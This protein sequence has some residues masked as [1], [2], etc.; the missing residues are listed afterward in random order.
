M[1]L[2][3]ESQWTVIACGV[4]AHADGVLDGEECDL[5]LAMIEGEADG[6]EYSAWLSTISD[7]ERLE[8][9]LSQLAPP[10]QSA[11]RDILETAWT[12]AVADGVRTSSER[13]ALGRIATQL[14]VEEVQLEFWREAWTE[15]QS[16]LAELVTDA[17]CIVLAGEAPLNSEARTT[18]R[19][20]SR[21][22]PTTDAHREELVGATA[23]PKNAEDIGRR[24][25]GIPKRR[26]QWVIKALAG[27]PG[28]ASRREDAQRR[29]AAIGA[30]AGLSAQ[31]LA[32]LLGSES[33]LRELLAET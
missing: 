8:E 19:A 6:E 22:V 16:A 28:K 10:P 32:A 30:S 12:L 17:G 9:M 13:E 25:R 14:G 4:M 7:R 26:R 21:A 23:I 29:L 3:L 18:I 27:I 24:L 31:T 20:L 33:V 1:A 15:G 11:H 5:L 2:S